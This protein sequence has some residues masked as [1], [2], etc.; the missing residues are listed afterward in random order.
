MV[1]PRAGRLRTPLGIVFKGHTDSYEP[2]HEHSR[3]LA[4]LRRGPPLEYKNPDEEPTITNTDGC[5]SSLEEM[6][7][8]VVLVLELELI[9]SR[10]FG[11][12]KSEF[13]GILKAIRK[14]VS[15]VCARLRVHT[16]VVCGRADNA[17]G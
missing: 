1:R 8:S 11:P 4:A 6:Q 9:E 17:Y 10:I 2:V 12:I 14:R 16:G 13:Q 7:S 15:K 3:L 5:V